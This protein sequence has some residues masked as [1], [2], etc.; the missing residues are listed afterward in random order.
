M[1]RAGKIFKYIAAV[2]ISL[3]L[4]LYLVSLVLETKISAVFTR[5][6]NKRLSAPVT[7]EKLNFSLLKRFPRASVELHD[8]LLQSPPAPG[9]VTDYPDTL[10]FADR[11]IL[12]L[13]IAPL[14]NKNY[15]VDR[16]DIEKGIIN[17]CRDE[18]GT[19]NT[20]I[21][22]RAEDTDTTVMNLNINN[23]NINSSSFTYTVPSRGFHL[24]IFVNNS[25]NKLN[26]D[27]GH[28]GLKSKSSTV[29]MRLATGQKYRL[30]GPY[31]VKFSAALQMTG[32]SIRIEEAE[33][34]INGIPLEGN[35]L[36]ITSESTI[37]AVLNTAKTEI[38]RLAEIILP[39]NIDFINKHDIGGLL[40]S[41]VRISGS[42][43]S[44]QAIE[45]SSELELS[46]GAFNIPSGDIQFEDIATRARLRMGFGKQNR[47]FEVSSPGFSAT[48]GKTSF[49]GSF[50]LRDLVNPYIDLIIA[51][52][53]PSPQLTA[54]FKEGN[55]ASSAGNIRLNARLSGSVPGKK[56]QGDFN[57]FELQRSVNM[58]L[59]AV[60]LE[61]P[62]LEGEISNINGNIMI[63]DNVW[64]DDLSMSYNNQNIALNGMITGFNDWLLKKDPSLRITA[65]LW[66]DR[67]DIDSFR[68][69]FM[70]GKRDANG[71]K[72]GEGQNDAAGRDKNSSR[73]FRPEINLNILCDSIIM[74]NFR[75]SLFEA[76][77]SYQPGLVDISSFS[78]NT[79][80]GFLSGNAAIAD[81]RDKGFAMRGWFDIENIDI[82][83]TFTTF[84]D[85]RQD[86]IK[87]ENLDGLITGTISLS[88]TT[89]RQLRINKKDL[90]LN[91]E[92]RITDGRLID[93]EPAYKLSRFIE[94]DELAEISFS[95]LENELII[96]NEMITIP[97]M[98][99]SSSAFN[100]SLEGNHGFDGIY[101]YHLR[102][103]L[104]DLLSKKK[105]A[106]VSE[107]GLIEDDGLGRTSLYL[108]INGDKNGSRVSHDTEALRSG[109]KEDLQREKQTIK[110]ILNEEY[111]WYTGDSITGVPAGNTRRFRITW[112]E[113]DSIKTEVAD[114]TGKKLPLLRLFK[115]KNSNK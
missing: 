49:Y 84:N 34:D 39:G 115:K 37:S 108:R 40:S 30:N 41:S 16:I 77:L 73:D 74:G 82:N 25:S 65:G 35:C 11:M 95:S 12:T 23:V 2:G 8:I 90:V 71:N 89:D 19:M 48:L 61:L 62:G 44:N 29:L 56:G 32:D 97:M 110:S 9:I 93:F 83:K 20:D 4:I 26:M 107:F 15:I 109:I 60:N 21:W 80:S 13:K 78:M 81:L 103:L 31:P 112:E 14:I 1:K 33:M 24:D 38:D 98:D 46:R 28:T 79:L 96:N 18:S 54:L 75:A 53:F 64:A 105:N 45:L 70:A 52:L 36:I 85:F 67:I 92:Y 104:S 86:Y 100:I 3:V 68:D 5:E 69:K 47:N 114:T 59:N 27:R 10:L 102:V 57:I 55:I 42:Y 88:A 43:G 72:V 87:S 94:V 111:G 66:S 7:M 91:G 76:D 58:G 6:L 63:A 113:T 17:I 50:L 22:V 106:K 101:E 99:I 51:G